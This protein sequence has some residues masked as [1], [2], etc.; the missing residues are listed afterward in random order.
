MAALGYPNK[1]KIIV[2][3]AALGLPLLTQQKIKKGG[4]KC[5][6][7]KKCLNYTP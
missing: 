4:K 3:E 1:D 6:S 7:I 2:G 5:S